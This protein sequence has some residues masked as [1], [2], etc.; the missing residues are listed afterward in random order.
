MSLRTH[1]EVGKMTCIR[2][3]IITLYAVRYWIKQ[4]LKLMLMII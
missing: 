2:K 1:Y 4:T 3:A